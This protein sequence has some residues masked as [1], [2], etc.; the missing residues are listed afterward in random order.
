[1]MMHE[2]IVLLKSYVSMFIN[3]YMSNEDFLTAMENWDLFW[4]TEI[5]EVKTHN[6]KYPIGE[7]GLGVRMHFMHY[8]S[9]SEA[10][11]AWDRRKTRID[12]NNMVIM[13]TNFEGASNIL[14]RF[15]KL[16]FKNK[17]IF[18]D[19][20]TSVKSAIYLKR[21]K[22]FKMKYDKRNKVTNI[23]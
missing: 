18:V 15:D 21:Y 20:P 10:K 4:N 6:C 5:V 9:F 23:F 19:E 17:I 14:Y 13:L 8:Q 1:M 16:T 3:L 12:M 7:G 11:S 22:K 2:Q